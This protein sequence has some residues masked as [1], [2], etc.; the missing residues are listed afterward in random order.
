MTES[1]IWKDV[2]GYDG[3]YKVS[4]KGN[5]HSVER[6]DTIGRK[7]GGRTLRPRYHKH[8][9]LHVVLHKNGIKKNKLVHRLVAE[10]FL[11]NPNNFL[12]VNHLDEIKDNNELSNLEWCDTMYNVNYGTRNKRVGRKLSKEVKAVN[13]ETGEVHTFGS[14]IEAKSKGYSNGNVSQACKGVYKSSNGK[15]IG[16]G[17]LYK[18]HRWSYEEE[19]NHAIADKRNAQK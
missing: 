15:L 4:N 5:I 17:H 3:L 19:A 9:Y 18:G 12:E 6:K 7:C 10:A 11:P 1:E 8:G 14:T 13:V 2:V 16:D